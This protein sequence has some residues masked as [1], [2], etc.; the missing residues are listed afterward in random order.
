MQ[1]ERVLKNAENLIDANHSA[2]VVALP[3]GTAQVLEIR[4][5]VSV[6]EGAAALAAPAHARPAQRG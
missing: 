6:G 5:E 2:V 1:V 4:P 3:V